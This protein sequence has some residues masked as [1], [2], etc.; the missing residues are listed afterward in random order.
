[1]PSDQLLGFL[2]V[3]VR[4]GM[5]AV[6]AVTVAFSVSVGV[7]LLFT[8][9]KRVVVPVAVPEARPAAEKAEPFPTFRPTAA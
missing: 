4:A 6:F 9:P 7:A 8:R 2:E 1:M 3:A 5:V